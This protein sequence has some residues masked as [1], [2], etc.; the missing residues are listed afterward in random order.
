MVIHHMLTSFISLDCL[1]C[2]A[3]CKFY[4]AF[5][6]LSLY[7]LYVPRARYEEEIVKAKDAMQALEDNQ[8]VVCCFSVSLLA[9]SCI[10]DRAWE[11][12]ALAALSRFVQYTKIS[13][14]LIVGNN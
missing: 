9:V 7:D 13:I 14:E 8:D 10:C 1:S 11:K 3:S 5:W 12:G 6:S 2:S 4:I